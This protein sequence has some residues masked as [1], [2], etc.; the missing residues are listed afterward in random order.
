MELIINEIHAE[1]IFHSP[2]ISL[3]SIFSQC[4]KVAA[5]IFLALWHHFSKIFHK[6]CWEHINLHRSYIIFHMGCS[7]FHIFCHFH[8]FHRIKMEKRELFAAGV[9]LCVCVQFCLL[10]FKMEET[11]KKKQINTG[12]HK[13]LTWVLIRCCYLLLLLLLYSGGHK[14]FYH[15][16]KR[17]PKARKPLW[18][19]RSL[20]LFPY[21]CTSSWRVHLHIFWTLNKSE[22]VNSHT[23]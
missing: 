5:C 17:H 6:F 21:H 14:K 8:M 20:I 19:I 22:S 23:H 10:P 4:T 2:S 16:W 13:I 3:W 7:K 11:K 12:K 9:S 1:D 18:N 15:R